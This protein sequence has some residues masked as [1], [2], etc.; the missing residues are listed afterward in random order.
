[1]IPDFQTFVAV[2]WSGSAARHLP[3]LQVASIS[4]RGREAGLVVP[5]SGRYWTRTAVVAHL[6][7]TARRRGPL[8]AGLDMGL[9]LPFLD[10]KSYFPGIAEAPHTALQLWRAVDAGCRDGAD[11]YGGAFCRPPSPFADYFNAPGRR[12]SRFDINRA[13]LTE[14]C[15]RKW[16]R[17]SSVFNG[18]GAGSVGMGSLAGMRVL[19][20]LTRRHHDLKVAIWPFQE[21]RNVDLVVL[22]IF[23]RLYVKQAGQDPRRWRERGFLP[24]V[25]KPY[26]CRPAAAD[27]LTEDETDAVLSAGALRHLARQRACWSPAAMTAAAARHEGW[28]FGVV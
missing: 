22:E 18:V 20:A 19:H 14:Q 21:T 23:P 24:D 7:E 6:L 12:G 3:G 17:P 28:I 25:M 27:G 10:A 1:M 26:G 16:T 9:A 2:D 15:C 5:P 11:F 4:A 8:L 13:R